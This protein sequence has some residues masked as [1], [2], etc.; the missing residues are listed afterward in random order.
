M[1]IIVTTCLQTL[2]SHVFTRVVVE[3]NNVAC[4]V[5]S[6]FVFRYEFDSWREFSYLDEEEKEKGERFVFRTTYYYLAIEPP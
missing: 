3:L 6:C 1:D 5:S 2:R 4:F